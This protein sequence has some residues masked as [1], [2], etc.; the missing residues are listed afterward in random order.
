MAGG[1]FGTA[2]VA[3]QVFTIP[4]NTLTLV[5]ALITEAIYAFCLVAGIAL[6]REHPFGRL[7]SIVVQAIQLPKYFSQVLI[8]MFSF[9]FDAYVYGILTANGSP[10]F[11][12]KFN[13]FAFNQLFINASEAPA[14]FGVS[15]TAC[16]FL[17]I[18]LRVKPTSVLSDDASQ[19]S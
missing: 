9:G 13:F 6:W 15:I 1:V 8:F 4:I 10:M 17:T 2:F 16:I 3:W 7:A 18:L 5:L 14:G 11:G 19:R 12:L